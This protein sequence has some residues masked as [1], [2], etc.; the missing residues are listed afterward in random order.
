MPTGMKRTR[1]LHQALADLRCMH[2]SIICDGNFLIHTSSR[3]GRQISTRQ[4]M[5]KLKRELARRIACWKSSHGLR[6]T[7]DK[8]VAIQ[9]KRGSPEI[10]FGLIR[11]YASRTKCMAGPSPGFGRAP[12]GRTERYFWRVR[13]GWKNGASYGPCHVSNPQNSRLS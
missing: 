12:N 1:D 13:C 9:L 2:E 11:R 4:K 6:C 7:S 10:R 3:C 5:T 8:T